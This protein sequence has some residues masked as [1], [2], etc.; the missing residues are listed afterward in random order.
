MLLNRDRAREVMERYE[1]D[2]LIAT[3]P[4]NI[5][6]VSDYGTDHSF[7]FGPQ[8]FGSAILPRDEDIPPTLIIQS[9]E[10]P[11]VAE[12]FTWM[13]E[14]RVQ[15]TIDIYVDRDAELDP[16]EQRLRDLWLA[17]RSGLPNRQRM[18]GRTL[19]EL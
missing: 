7:H 17:G 6:Y 13:P 10:L 16:A 12:R 14:V 3:I 18:L 15:Y 1:L 9:W 2:A 8:G 4:E 5:C 11:V 19:E